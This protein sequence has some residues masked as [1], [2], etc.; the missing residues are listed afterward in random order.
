[1]NICG[2]GVC[3]CQGGSDV[4]GEDSSCDESRRPIVGIPADWDPRYYFDTQYGVVLS[5][6][7]NE[8]ISGVNYFMDPDMKTPV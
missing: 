6:E 3:V 7:K 2:G 8:M 5:I 4:I 1:M